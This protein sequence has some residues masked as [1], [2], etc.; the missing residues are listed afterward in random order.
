MRS[1][2]ANTCLTADCIPNE[3]RFTPIARKAAKLSLVTVSGLHSIVISA[4]GKSVNSDLI[5]EIT[6]PISSGCIS[7]GVPPPK[8]IDGTLAL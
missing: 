3:T 5:A 2:V 6:R 8:K 7:D 1:S 4:S